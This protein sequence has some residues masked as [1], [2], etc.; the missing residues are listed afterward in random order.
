MVFLP[1]FS[2]MDGIKVLLA[3]KFFFLKGGSERVFFQERDFLLQLGVKVIDFS[4]EDS[5]NFYS[6]HSSYFVSN[7]DYQN[8]RGF[9]K[10]LCEAVQ[11]VHSVEAIKKLTKLIEMESPDIAHLH[12]VYHQITPSIIP[13]LKKH[14]VK[15]VVTLHDGKLICPGYHMLDRGKVC[16]NCRNG[17]FWRPAVKN[18]QGS[19]L[20]GLLL[21]IEAYW[22]KWAGSY[23]QV[24]RFLVPS[25][26]MA[27]LISQRIPKE[28]IS[29]LHNGV[30]INKYLP[31]YNGKGYTL[32]FGRIS[33]E[34]GIETLLKAH[35]AFTG[36]RN[37][38]VVGTG[39]LLKELRERYHNVEF[40]GYKHGANLR[41][42]IANSAFVVAPSECYENCSMVVL[43]AMAMGKPVI[44]TRIGGIPEQ[45]EE[46]KTGL[47][48]EA[49]NVQDLRDKM[50]LLWDDQE[51]RAK[52]GKA[53]R[54]KLEKE[55]S[56]N[57]HC[58]RLLA[59]YEEV[60]SE[61]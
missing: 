49:G 28:K 43:E 51:L 52:M 23:E 50:A 21:T 30:D 46:R 16:V 24:D 6:P 47:L 48:F 40:L 4:M 36:K 9:L 38:K 33:K 12:N 34:K 8:D 13:L 58:A 17:S 22:H 19:R 56:M 37:L 61:I 53:S 60:L 18:C 39:P 57:S 1:G 11:L 42:I 25:R 15:V 27:D 45:I 10:K 3:N 2:T 14:G 5:Q 7:I 35:G 26:F 31:S 20:R 55:Y 29:V 44:G 41:G 32:Y 59:I 54:E